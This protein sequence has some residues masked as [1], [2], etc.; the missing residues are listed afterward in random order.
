M[1]PTVTLLFTV[2]LTLLSMAMAIPITTWPRSLF[3]HALSYKPG[4]PSRDNLS[5]HLRYYTTSNRSKAGDHDQPHAYSQATE[6]GSEGP[7]VLSTPGLLVQ[8]SQ[9]ERSP[10]RKYSD[11]DAWD[12]ASWI[13]G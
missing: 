10:L 8:S 11:E 4:S 3:D 9:N 1:R 7:N 12:A 13:W 6:Y 5:S 2:Y